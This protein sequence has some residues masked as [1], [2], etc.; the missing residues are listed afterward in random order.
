LGGIRGHRGR[1]EGYND[2]TEA[3]G[4]NR[5]GQFFFKQGYFVFFKR[6]DLKKKYI[7]QY[8]ILL[9]TLRFIGINNYEYTRSEAAF[10]L[11]HVSTCQCCLCEQRNRQFRLCSEREVLYF[12]SSTK[13]KSLGN[14]AWITHFT[15]IG[16]M[17]TN[18]AP[19]MTGQ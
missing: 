4:Q 2:T 9:R 3:N 17:L 12:S 13:A 19:A 11:Q 5:V 15:S 16:E 8:S 1:L 14:R 18:L 7:R 6:L 10:K